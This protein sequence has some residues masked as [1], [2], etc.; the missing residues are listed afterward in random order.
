MAVRSLKALQGRLNIE[1]G[2]GNSNSY[3]YPHW[4]LPANGV[5]KLR[6]L[7]D[8]DLENELIVYVEYKEHTLNIGDEYVRIACPKN[9]G[10]DK[11][12]P[13]CERSSRFYKKF[14]NGGDKADEKR[15][16]YYYRDQYA[17]LRALIMKDGLEYADGETAATGSVRPIK[18][19]F[20][21]SSKLK[22]E[23]GKLDEVDVFW[24]LDKGIDFDIDKQMKKV[25]GGDDMADY[26]IASGFARKESS[27]KP[28]WRENI[29][30]E[31]L[32]ALIPT[33]PTYDEVQAQLDA[34]DN[35]EA[36]ES[37]GANS[38]SDDKTQS[39]E[40]LMASID[41][42]RKAKTPVTADATDTTDDNVATDD[43]ALASLISD[44]ED[45][46]DFLTQLKE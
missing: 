26:G 46:D 28:E 9:G 38:T 24:D 16:K 19:S 5:T 6:I 33:L 21:L 18:F 17:L 29:T 41:S 45:D 8:P 43:D 42:R 2:E 14:K 44:D 20:Q 11:L 7:E 10:K 31:P 32:S 4:K 36:A 3:W 15:G 25:P 23:I 12:C 30:D 40:D 22:A 27:V 13:I 39:E 35:G 34:H 37:D 1:S